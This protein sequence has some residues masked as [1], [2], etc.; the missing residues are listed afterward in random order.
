MNT[1]NITFAAIVLCV[2]LLVVGEGA[3][4]EQPRP[5]EATRGK[6]SSH[7]SCTTMIDLCGLNCPAGCC[8]DRC[9]HSGGF[10]GGCDFQRM[11]G[12]HSP[13]MCTYAK[14]CS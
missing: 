3:G 10:N 14:P 8:A 1:V 6:D 13:C 9:Q 12:T 4:G 7:K 5:I 2:L 11:L